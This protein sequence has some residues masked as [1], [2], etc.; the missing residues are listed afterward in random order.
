MKR[1]HQETG[2]EGR[3]FVPTLLDWVAESTDKRMKHCIGLAFM[4]LLLVRFGLHENGA[5]IWQSRPVVNTK[6]ISRA[7]GQSFPANFRI[8]VRTLMWLLVGPMT[9]GS[10]TYLEGTPDQAV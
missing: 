7:Y 6:E 8:V 9:L 3:I 2:R 5:N 1:G 10:A 4:D